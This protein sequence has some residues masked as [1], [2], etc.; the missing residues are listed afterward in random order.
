MVFINYFF[1]AQ[2]TWRKNV[3]KYTWQ[4]YNIIKDTKYTWQYEFAVNLTKEKEVFRMKKE[5]ILELSKRDNQSGDELQKKVR[6]KGRVIAM[7][8][9][10]ITAIV[11]LLL[12]QF[13]AQ[14]FT[15]FLVLDGVFAIL[16]AADFSY[17]LYCYIKGKDKAE[18]FTALVDLGF[19]IW[20]IYDLVMA[21]R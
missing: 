17:Y 7:N 11:F 8:V 4:S 2:K 14:K 16:F 20:N 9:M 13:V 5:E 21:L 15:F 12:E 18:L 19:L 6:S 10:Y 3:D 1:D